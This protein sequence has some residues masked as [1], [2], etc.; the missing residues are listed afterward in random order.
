MKHLYIESSAGH[1]I[2]DSTTGIVIDR[3]IQD[4]ERY[5]KICMFNLE[6]VPDG[7]DTVDILDIGYWMEDGTYEPKIESEEI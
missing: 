4:D 7:C 6:D 5:L 1:F 3:Y 2:C